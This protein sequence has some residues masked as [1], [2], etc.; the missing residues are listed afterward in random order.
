LQLLIQRQVISSV[1]ALKTRPR[2]PLILKLF[3]YLP[4]LR[5]IPGRLLGMGF[6]PE[7]VRTP[8]ILP[9]PR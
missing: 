4:W 6:R 5:R 1:L 7:H 2:P 8:E 3:D 9:P